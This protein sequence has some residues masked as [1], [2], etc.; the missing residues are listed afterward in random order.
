[1]VRYRAKNV[2]GWGPYSDA[3][4]IWTIMV[5]DVPQNVTTTLVGSNVIISWIAPD[6]RGSTI[7]YYNVQILS[8][9]GVY[10]THPNFCN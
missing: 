9:S 8:S 7:I 10:I 4:A 3:V 1:M 6:S 2:F 5:P